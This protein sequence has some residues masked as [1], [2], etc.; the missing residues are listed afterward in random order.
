MEVNGERF[1]CSSRVFKVGLTKGP[2]R[3]L[4]K[5]WNRCDYTGEYRRPKCSTMVSKRQRGITGHLMESWLLLATLF[6][7]ANAHASPNG[8]WHRDELFGS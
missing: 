8:T 7:V 5:L 6:I 2:W 3:R 4:L 1:S